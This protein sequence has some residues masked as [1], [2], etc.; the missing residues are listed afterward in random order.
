MALTLGRTV[1]SNMFS[2]WSIHAVPWLDIA[3]RSCIS[4]ASIANHA[5]AER[6]R[7]AF[8]DSDET[9][10]LDAAGGPSDAVTVEMLPVKDPLMVAEQ[11][12]NAELQAAR[13]G[14]AALSRLQNAAQ[15]VWTQY[16]LRQVREHHEWSILYHALEFMSGPSP[17]GCSAH[18]VNTLR[19]EQRTVG[20]LQP[21][22]TAA[23]GEHA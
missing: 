22:F 12:I 20:H 2:Y 14:M 21:G 10:L 7:K 16:S 6:L 5:A 4:R 3:Q 19:F 15:E 8:D 13:A 11:K 23:L 18:G 17:V 1:W 9:R